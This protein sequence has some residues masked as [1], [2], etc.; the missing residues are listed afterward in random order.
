MSDPSV[1]IIIFFFH[2]DVAI[3]F[4]LLHLFLYF[5]AI[6]WISFINPSFSLVGFNP[7]LMKLFEETFKLLPLSSFLGF[8]KYLILALDIEEIFSASALTLCCS[9]V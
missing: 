3:I 2:N 6:L 7:N 8:E 4:D 1:S 9:V 5:V